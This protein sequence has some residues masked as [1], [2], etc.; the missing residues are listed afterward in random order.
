VIEQPPDTG[1]P[2]ARPFFISYAREDL[3]AYAKDS[4]KK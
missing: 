1:I 4:L 2:L 3:E